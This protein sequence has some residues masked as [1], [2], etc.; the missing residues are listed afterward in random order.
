MSSIPSTLQVKPLYLITLNM[1]LQKKEEK[2]REEKL[3]IF[4]R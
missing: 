1:L 2:K 4:K 3:V